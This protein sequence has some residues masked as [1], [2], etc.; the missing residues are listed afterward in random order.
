[1]AE[2]DVAT[3]TWP[4]RHHFTIS[5]GTRTEIHVVVAKIRDGEVVG[6]GECFP[7]SRYNEDVEGVAAAI[8]SLAPLVGEGLGREQLLDAMPAGAARNAV[9]C[10]L[11]DLEAKRAQS[12]EPGT[13]TGTR[14]WTLAGL[15]AFPPL[16]TVMTISI[17]APEVMAAAATKAVANGYRNLKV[18]L[19][20]G[21]GNDDARITAIRAA[22]PDVVLIVDANEG[23]RAEGLEGHL[24]AMHRAGVS[25]VEQPLPAGDDDVLSSVSS[26]V[27]IGADES[28]H[29]SADLERLVG[30]YNVIN[31]KLDKA[32]GLT[33]AL[34]MA[35][36]AKSL[37]FDLMV[38]CMLGTS[39]AM[40]PA[41]IVA[42]RASYVDL[43]GP[44]WL[45]GDRDAPIAFDAGRIA[46]FAPA[47]WG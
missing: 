15:D 40:A 19:G 44:L 24:S 18:K 36:K 12:A 16:N 10:A 46:E 5:R 11:W 33:E 1:M 31:I 8:R 27:P 21:D 3:E 38:G 37:G 26:P 28:C 47:L 4:L 34:K 45:A 35:D 7:H 32:G 30:K 39:L 20:S 25:M 43:D 42:A 2:L 22:A 41:T 6:R 9:D 14:A 13:G 29:T 17:D 23:W